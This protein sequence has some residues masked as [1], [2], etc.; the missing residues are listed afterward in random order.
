VAD[1]ITA[2]VGFAM[3]MAASFAKDANNY[4]RE[5]PLVKQSLTQELL[6]SHKQSLVRALDHAEPSFSSNTESLSLPRLSLPTEMFEMHKEKLYPRLGRPLAAQ[7]LGYYAMA[8]RL[9]NKDIWPSEITGDAAAGYLR[10]AATALS[11]LLAT[12]DCLNG[13]NNGNKGLKLAVDDIV[14]SNWL[15]VEVARDDKLLKSYGKS[16]RPR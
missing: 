2:V 15:P 6:Y 4:F 10:E 7:V 3:G 16:G 13:K 5:R 11:F 14:N 12:V 9:S 1:L 8:S